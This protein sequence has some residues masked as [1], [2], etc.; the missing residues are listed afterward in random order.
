MSLF[1]KIS[2]IMSLFL[3]VVII[4]VM[5]LNFNSA[6]KYAQEEL[7]VNAQN[8]ATSLSLS[9]SNAK[10]NT[11]L[12]STMINAVFDNGYYKEITLLD[13][14]GNIIFKRTKD[15]TPIQIP[16]WFTGLYSFQTPLASANV[17]SGWNPVGQLQITS[18]QDNAHIKLYNNFLELLN[19]SAIISLVTLG[20]LFILLK[21]ILSSLIKL[22]EQAEA[23]SNNNF[24]INENIPSTSEFKEVTLAM[25]KMVTKVKDI[26]EKEATSVQN[27]HRVLY[28][29]TLTSL[30]NRNFF[31]LKMND[32]LSSQEVDANGVILTLF[33]DGVSEAN[34][35]LGHEK[36]NSLIKEI[37]SV[38]KERFKD[39]KKVLLSRID[40]TKFSVIFPGLQKEDIFEHA[41]EILAQSIMKLEH[42][43]ISH[44][45]C[46]I[47]IA[48][49]NYSIKD[50]VPSLLD[51]IEKSLS[52]VHKNSI[53]YT[54]LEYFQDNTL[55]RNLIEK[56]INDHSIALALQD[57]FDNEN[58]ILH[59]EAYVRLFDEEQNMHEAGNF[60]P[61]IHKMHLDT[62]LDKSVINYAIKEPLLQDK[63]VAINISLRFLQDK[64]AQRWL[65][66]RLSSISTSRKLNFEIS[67]HNLLNCVDEA[68]V[69]SSML[70]QTG[71][72]FGIDRFNIEEGQ[73]LNYLQIIKPEYIRIDSLYLHEMLQNEQGQKNPALQDLIESLD[74]K[75][76]A[77]NIENQE[78]KIFLEKMG[79][80][81][82]QGSL[83]SKPKLA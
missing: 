83:L 16:S 52:N 62:K 22:K 21:L 44:D 15:D 67:N 5:T 71:N 70:K 74:I 59:S 78:T 2:I 36:V 42:A 13:N 64:A 69:F 25:N 39:E 4:A 82:F 63:D 79:I 9:L 27:Y 7:Y 12:M 35:A 26:F 19:A 32:Y 8:S 48:Q 77:S 28:T 33:F 45:Q 50:T 29:D 68:G 10:G 24:I 54:Q 46:S 51:N 30:G 11:S 6:Q 31:E 73:N 43:S 18:L 49:I 38:I 65:K 76:I 23:V 47:K 14:D 72:N 34:K 61:L 58:N 53:S 66:E 41:D 37:A 56:R 81:Y 57:V 17:S 60:I 40:G 75:I 3:L 20:L 1:K 55:D 80:K